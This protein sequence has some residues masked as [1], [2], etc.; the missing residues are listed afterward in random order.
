[1]PVAQGGETFC[2]SL[3]IDNCVVMSRLQVASKFMPVSSLIVGM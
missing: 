2:K 3:D 1:M